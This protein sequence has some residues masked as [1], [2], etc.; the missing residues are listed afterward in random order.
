GAFPEIG[1]DND[2]RLVVSGAGFQP[3]LPLTHIVGRSQIRV[4]VLS[5]N[6]Q[7]PEFVDQEEIDHAGDGVG[8]IHGRGAILEDVYVIDH[9]EGYQVDVHAAASPGCAQRTIGDAFAVDQ[10]QG[11]LGQQAAQVELD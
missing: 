9:R 7:S 11:F 10:N 4:P 1:N 2:I 3:C 5:A 6:L 8:A